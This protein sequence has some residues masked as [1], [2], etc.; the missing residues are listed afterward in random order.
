MEYWL[1]AFNLLLALIV[2]TLNTETKADRNTPKFKKP[3]TS[4][5]FAICL[6]IIVSIFQLKIQLEKDNSN[7]DQKIIDSLRYNSLLT[8]ERDDSFSFVKQYV[9][10]SS[11]FDKQIKSMNSQI[12]LSKTLI[13]TQKFAIRKSEAFNTVLK[14]QLN[15]QAYKLEDLKLSAKLYIADSQKNIRGFKNRVIESIE[16]G[17][18]PI[19]NL[20]SNNLLPDSTIEDEKDFARFF[21]IVSI[22][23]WIDTADCKW[24]LR[25]GGNT[26][27]I[28]RK[29]HEGLVDH[30]LNG[31]IFMEYSTKSESFTVKISGLETFQHTYLGLTSLKQFR[32]RRIFIH[33]YTQNVG[34]I[35]YTLESLELST[36][37]GRK[38]VLSA[39][40]PISTLKFPHVNDSWNQHFFCITNSD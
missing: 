40:R 18:A 35:S 25:C 9:E 11:S 28:E 14:E 23:L 7:R 15:D 2:A 20:S 31:R 5:I 34:K 38:L 6:I 3:T 1:L 24:E 30:K 12:S 39:I 32:N 10:D 22:D 29:F 19:I 27:N 26:E 37:G 33:V 13:T 21:K 8:K 16:P 4:G 17:H 36:V